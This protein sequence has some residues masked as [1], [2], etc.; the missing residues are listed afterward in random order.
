MSVEANVV[1]REKPGALV[2]PAEAAQGTTVFA[3]MAD[4]AERRAI[5]IGIRGP[6][7]IEV[8]SG[9]YRGRTG[10][11]AGPTDLARRPPRA[12]R[13]AAAP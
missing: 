8:V 10:R 11:V 1:T 6:R 9:L 5:T 3:I 4:R 2:I 7:A 12:R 13:R